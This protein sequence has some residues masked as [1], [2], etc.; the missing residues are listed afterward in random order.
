MSAKKAPKSTQEMDA[1]GGCPAVP[2]CLSS[3]D[4][5]KEAARKRHAKWYAA[6]KEKAKERAR[7][8]Y[9]QNLQRAKTSRK[10]WRE[11]VKEKTDREC[12]N[13]GGRVASGEYR[14]KQCASEIQRRYAQKNPDKVKESQRE[15]WR[16]NKDKKKAKDA[17]HRRKNPVPPEK[18][19]AKEARL[20]ENLANCYIRRLLVKKTDLK[21]SDIPQ[22]L[23]ELKRKHMEIHRK[24][25]TI[26]Q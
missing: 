1:H 2:C 9:A 17:R 7:E 21:H 6:N 23:V 5:K 10:E 19:K 8:W 15:Y 20:K 4:S 12:K 13:C 16:K 24:L 26:E 25:K 22:E 11:N 18:V 3:L 14:C